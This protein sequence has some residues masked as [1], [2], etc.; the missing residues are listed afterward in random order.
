MK[1][2]KGGSWRAYTWGSR[3]AFRLAI[4]LSLADGTLGFRLTA[5]RR[6]K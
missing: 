6:T 2:I 3:P 4:R 5:K 1:L